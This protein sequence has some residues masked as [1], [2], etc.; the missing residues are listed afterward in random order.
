MSGRRLG[1][2]LAR[3]AYGRQVSSLPDQ[4]HAGLD[5]AIDSVESF[6]IHVGE[7]TYLSI[8]YNIFNIMY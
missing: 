2:N 7:T 4:D 8:S 5:V 6:S 1:L 3:C